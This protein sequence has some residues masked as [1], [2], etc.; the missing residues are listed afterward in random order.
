M[1]ATLRVVAVSSSVMGRPSTIFAPMV[2]KNPG[3][4]RAQPAPVSSLAPGS[5]LPAT[6]MPSFQLSPVIGA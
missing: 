6:R 4:T 5:G 1:T 2:S 3:I